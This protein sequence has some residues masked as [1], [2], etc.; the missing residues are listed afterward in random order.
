MNHKSLRKKIKNKSGSKNF[1]KR[2]RAAK[3]GW[4]GRK[5]REEV[6]EQLEYDYADH[7]NYLQ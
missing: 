4:L 3:L 5:G 7:T 2:S 1:L 6:N